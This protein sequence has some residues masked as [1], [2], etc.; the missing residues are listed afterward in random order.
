MQ[1]S[2]KREARGIYNLFAVLARSFRCDLPIALGPHE[3]LC[4][5]FLRRDLTHSLI[6]LLLL[7]PQARHFL[8]H[9]PIGAAKEQ[10]RFGT[11][12]SKRVIRLCVVAEAEKGEQ[13][14]EVGCRRS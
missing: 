2:N 3:A 10:A 13:Q 14:G 1:V 7:G 12:T 9:H 6:L 8:R 4:F 5:V 11:F